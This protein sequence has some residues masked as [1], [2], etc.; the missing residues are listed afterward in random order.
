[1]SALLRL[2]PEPAGARA[3]GDDHG[4]RAVLV[5]LDPDAER[6]L[7][8]VDAGHVVGDELGAEALGLAAELAIISGPMIPSA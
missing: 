5:V 4:A 1:M 8:E 3:G 7:R 2:E 6:P